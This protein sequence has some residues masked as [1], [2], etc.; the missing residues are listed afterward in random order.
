MSELKLKSDTAKRKRLF[1][2]DSFS[3]PAKCHIG[4]LEYLLQE[5][6]SEGDV[7]LDPMAGSGSILLGTLMGRHIICVELETKFVK[8]AQ[9]NLKKLSSQAL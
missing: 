7:V 4:M 2:P 8:M 1:T 5:F 6:T 9:D 3:H